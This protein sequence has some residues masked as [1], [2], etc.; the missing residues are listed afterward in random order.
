MS[1]LTHT[2]ANLDELQAA[3]SKAERSILYIINFEMMI[4]HP[5]KIAQE[6]TY[7]AAFNLRAHTL[8]SS[9]GK[10]RELNFAIYNVANARYDAC[11]RSVR[12]LLHMM[13]SK[14]GNISQQSVVQTT[15]GLV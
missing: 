9:D 1:V 4:Q 8:P 14:L 7:P 10:Y 15:L 6:L 2:Q 5:H 11:S 12:I 3:V 13:G